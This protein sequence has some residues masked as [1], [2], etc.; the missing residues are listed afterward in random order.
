MQSRDDCSNKL[1]I[2]AAAV[3]RNFGTGDDGLAQVLSH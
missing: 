3:A 2:S 1:A